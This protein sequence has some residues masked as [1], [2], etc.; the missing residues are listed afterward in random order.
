MSADKLFSSYKKRE[1][2]INRER[3]RY[4]K[5][6]INWHL[7]PMSVVQQLRSPPQSPQSSGAASGKAEEAVLGS[8]SL[9]SLMV[10]VDVKQH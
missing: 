10:S 8:P 6:V 9:I 1:R 5:K 4:H 2:E 7:V 3:Y